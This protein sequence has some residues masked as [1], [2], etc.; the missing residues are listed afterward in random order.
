MG[1]FM[2]YGLLILVTPADI[3]RPLGVDVPE[4]CVTVPFKDLTP[5]QAVAMEYLS[6]TVLILI[7]GGVWDPRNSKHQDSIPVKFGLA[8]MAIG[9]VVG[10][11]TG[12]SWLF[13]FLNEIAMK[14]T[15][16]I[17]SLFVPFQ[18]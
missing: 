5:I 8:I 14:S 11:Y 18:A 7:C 3:F 6:T 9:T 1:A 10:P 13:S 12:A 17:I 2:G 15:Q 4:L 16:V